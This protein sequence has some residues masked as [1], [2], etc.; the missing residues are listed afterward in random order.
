MMVNPLSLSEV[1]ELLKKEQKRRELNREQ[2]IA[3]E[4]AEHFAKLSAK[5]SRALI[6][7]LMKIDRMKEYQACKIADLLP[8]D[9][10]EVRAI[11][12]KE[13]FTPSKEEIE[14]IV[15]LVEKYR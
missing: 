5:K 13:R 1:K 15:N 7:K 8:F 11:F 6:N 2:K 9:E 14:D 4:H 12:L 10:G 3:L